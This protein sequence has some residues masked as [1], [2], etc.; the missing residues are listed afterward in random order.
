MKRILFTIA[1]LVTLSVYASAQCYDKEFYLG[2]TVSYGKS[3]V[4]NLPGG[5]DKP[6]AAIGISAITRRSRIWA[7]GANL[8]VASMGF[9]VNREEGET[10]ISPIYL[11]LPVRGYYFLLH[12]SV[13]PLLY[14]G[15]EVGVK[16]AENSSGVFLPGAPDGKHVASWDAGLTGGAGFNIRIVQNTWIMVTADYYRGFVDAAKWIGGSFNENRNFGGS[17][18]VLHK[19]K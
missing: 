1:T 8:T 18:T 14:L 6:S 10:T 7:W 17:L 2:G 19:I 11:R 15:P 16:I 5:G 4:D 13:Q 3:W 12:G 9:R